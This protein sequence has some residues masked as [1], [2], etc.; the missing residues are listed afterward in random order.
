MGD[1][2]KFIDVKM[3]QGGLIQI[4]FLI[5]E[6]NKHER[7]FVEPNKFFGKLGESMMESQ[8]KWYKHNFLEGGGSG[9]LN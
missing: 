1:E 2:I 9:I 3:I 7:C 8:G 4:D 6:T 5:V